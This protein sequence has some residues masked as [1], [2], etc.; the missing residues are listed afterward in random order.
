MKNIFLYFILFL[1]GI[2]FLGNIS[3]VSASGTNMILNSNLESGTAGLPTDWYKG[4]WGKNISKFVYPAPGYNSNSAAN[5][6]VSGYTNGDAKWFFNEVAITG[7]QTYTFSDMYDSNIVTSVTA[8]YKLSDG[9]YSYGYLGSAPKTTGFQKFTADFTAPANVVSVTV[10]HVINSVGYLTIDDASLTDKIVVVTPPPVVEEPTPSTD[11]NLVLNSTLEASNGSVPTNWSKGGWGTNVSTYTYPTTGY[12]SAKAAKIDVTSYTNGDAKWFFDEV[13][14]T[15]GKTYTFSDM[16]SSSTD[17]YVTVRYKMLDGSYTYGYLGYAGKNTGW[18]EFSSDLIVPAN[19]VSLTVFHVINSIGYLVIDNVSIKEKVIVITP[20]TPPSTDGNLVLNNNLETANGNSPKYWN[21]GGWG[22]NVSTY[23]YPALGY[24]SSKSAKVEITSYTNGDAKWFFDDIIV[25]AG[26]TY[27]FSDMYDSNVA[28]SITAR[29]KLTDGSYTYAYIGSVPKSTG[30]RKYTTNITIPQNVIGLTVFHVINTVG[31]LNI[32]DVS[33]VL[34][35][36][37][38]FTE[39]MI[40]F[41][42]DDGFK[43]I[44]DR[45]IPILDAAGIKSTQAIF[46][47]SYN[48]VGYMS[49]AQIK[50]LYDNGHEIASHSVTHSDL[51][52]ITLSGARDEIINSKA[53]LAAYGIDAKTFVYPYGEYNDTTIDILQEAGYIGARSVTR[54]Y[55]TPSSDRFQLKDQ[56]ITTDT[57]FEMVKGY[58]DTALA[59]KKW[60]I[61]ELHDQGDNLGFYSNT[62]ALLQQ[63]VDYVKLKNM[64]TVTLG[65]GISKMN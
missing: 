44:Y 16:Y 60:L 59:E 28:T 64:K 4:N 43:N 36:D 39:G 13:A 49:K 52:Q 18:Q 15:P 19:T 3:L 56:E 58:I 25:T 12:N 65:E 47:A 40:T 24:N 1:I 22:N 57:T 45:A 23:S 34:A 9:T 20:P 11:G 2:L 33:L 54:G 7:G 62:P 53:D 21:K 42:F 41:T 29:Y 55:N 35:P 17:T 14:V 63:I 48:Y 10:F 32:D 51:N 37:D 5:I 46:T 30:W 8:R 61:L 50:E 27:T 38:I 6:V 26:K 31:Y